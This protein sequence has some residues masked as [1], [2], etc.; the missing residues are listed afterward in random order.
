MFNLSRLASLKGADAK[1]ENNLETSNL[2]FQFFLSLFLFCFVLS[3]SEC[4][5]RPFFEKC[6]Y[7]GR[8][9]LLINVYALIISCLFYEVI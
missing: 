1:V 6:K 2:Y 4:K 9:F 7:Y 8:L 3:Q 5:G